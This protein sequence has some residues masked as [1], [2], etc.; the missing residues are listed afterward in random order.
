MPLSLPASIFEEFDKQFDTTAE[1]R[2][3]QARGDF[4]LAFPP[5]RLETL[6]LDEYVIGTGRP[7]F[8]AYV[9]VKTKSWAN[10][11]GATAFKFGIYFGRTKSDPR[12]H[13]RVTAKFGDDAN[14]AFVAVRNSLLDLISAGESRRFAAVDDN[15]LSQM[16]KAKI[17]SLY[18]P[19]VY[20]NVCS[21]EHIQ[22]L[23][24]E[25]GIPEEFPISR[26]QHFLLEEKRANPITRD[27]SNPKFMTFLYNT[28]I[29]PDHKRHL[30]TLRKRNPPKVNID[31]MLENRRKI[32]E[33]SEKY[34]L[35]WEKERLL[36]SGCK[37]LIKHI[38]DVRSAP[39]CGYDFRSHTLPD[40][41]RFIEVKSVGRNR[42]GSGYRFFL[43]DRE[44]SI[45]QSA[46]HK[47]DY[48]FY[49]VF[50]EDN[51]PVAVESWK[52]ADLYEISELGPNGYVVAFDRED[53]DS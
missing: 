7:T 17:L 21:A 14:T 28:Y 4:L 52:A 2:A 43:S 27:W 50:Y 3:A 24:A 39:A 31:E 41:K 22:L 47:D 37:Q 36:G 42:A 12:R 32:G 44:H 34:A 48:Y 18:F 9:E 10:I 35:E 33:I 23:A 40:R 5:D 26:Q 16:F 53:E 25:L 46:D 8:C 6:T 45:S 38:E 11:L 15:K 30:K 13:Y 1:D 29:R 20:M 19:E 51:K 49:L